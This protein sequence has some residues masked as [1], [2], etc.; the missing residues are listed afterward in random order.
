MNYRYDT[1]RMS[2]REIYR[3]YENHLG[4]MKAAESMRNFPQAKGHDRLARK[5]LD[6]YFEGVEKHINRYE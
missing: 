4:M 3:A 1:S 6:L 5:L 2:L